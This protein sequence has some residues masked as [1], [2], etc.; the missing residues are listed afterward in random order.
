M[1]AP[2]T[3]SRLEAILRR[4]L[5]PS[6]FTLEDQSHLHAGHKAAGGGGHFSVVLRSRRF[7]GLAPLRRQRLVMDAVREL[8]EKNEIHALALRCIPE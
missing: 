3:A 8:M 1:R 7:N 5:S 4:E 2:D 6:E